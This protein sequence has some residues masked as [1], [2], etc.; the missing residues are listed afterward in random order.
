MHTRYIDDYLLATPGGE[1]NAATRRLLQGEILRRWSVTDQDHHVVAAYLPAGRIPIA[2]AR[3]RRHGRRAEISYR[4]ATP[5]HRHAGELLVRELAAMARA[6][7]LQ[8]SEGA[9]V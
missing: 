8:P 9:I 5:A 7:G 2:I 4:I 3:L 6:A 1:L